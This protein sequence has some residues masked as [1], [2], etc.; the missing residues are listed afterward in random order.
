M[1]PLTL[2]QPDDHEYGEVDTRLTGSSND[3]SLLQ[4]SKSGYN[5]AWPEEIA[6]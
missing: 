3:L 4:V 5:P 1:I 6:K 2:L